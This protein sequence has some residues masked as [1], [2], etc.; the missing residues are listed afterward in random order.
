M[1]PLTDEVQFYP[2]DAVSIH[3]TA[4]DT[5]M[6]KAY[7]PW[8]TKATIV[9]ESTT[10]PG[11]YTVRYVTAAHGRKRTD[12][13]D[14]RLMPWTKLQLVKR[15]PG[16]TEH[17]ARDEAAGADGS[18]SMDDF[19]WPEYNYCSEDEE[20]EGHNIAEDTDTVANTSVYEHETE[21]PSARGELAKDVSRKKG[22]A[23]AHIPCVR[24]FLECRKHEQ[25]YVYI[26]IYYNSHAQSPYVYILIYYNSQVQSSSVYILIYY[27]SHAQSSSMYILIYYNSHVKT[28]SMYILTYYNSQAQSSY[29]YILIYYNSYAIITCVHVL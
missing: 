18:N 13:I 19:E 3:K 15:G 23:S 24:I 12:E 6:A 8:A 1:A 4:Y 7:H 17:K 2:G 10:H 28:S 5:K 16:P 25:S 20:D 27:N 22:I 11:F 14:K 26:L 29:V 21:G 9:T